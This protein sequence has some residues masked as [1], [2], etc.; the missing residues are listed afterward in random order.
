M[1]R[2]RWRII[3][4]DH[5]A[6][7]ALLNGELDFTA[8]LSSSDYFGERVASEEFGERFYTG[9]FDTPVMSYT[10]YNL[11]RPPLDDVRVRRALSMGFDWEAF[12]DGYYRGLATRVT[13]EVYPGSPYYDPSVEPIAYDPGGASA[14]LAEAGWYDRDGD[15][16]VDRDGQPLELEL[17][18][19]GGSATGL[20]YGQKLREDLARLGVRLELTDP[21]AAAF[22][23][24]VWERDF[25][26]AHLAWFMPVESDPEQLW[27]SRWVG[28][29]TGN[30]T[31]F[32]D[33]EVDRLIDALQ[34]ELDRDRRI[35]LFHRLHRQVHDQQAY[36]YGVH[37]PR[38][39]AA[40]RRVRNLQTFA[41]EPGYS[42]RR[43]YLQ[44]D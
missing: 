7:L 26:L 32:A 44:E 35:A 29:Q 39:F 31:G 41:M 13:S 25:E 37:V 16:V 12:I 4:D 10:A 23:E 3:R 30:H 17:L 20:A 2:I 22:F 27:H 18:V 5:T 19:P 33:P 38:K 24:R 8:R 42:L 21:D 1:D 36:S 9:L 6:F 43:W 34:V 28:T 11:D 15:G 40:S 14:L